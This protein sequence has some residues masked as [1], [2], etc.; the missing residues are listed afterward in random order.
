V[1]DAER[2][3]FGGSPAPNRSL[4]IRRGFPRRGRHRNK[5]AP[6]C[7]TGPEASAAARA[8]H[9]PRPVGRTQCIRFETAPAL[10]CL[11][12]RRRAMSPT[13]GIRPAHTL[14]RASCVPPISE[15]HPMCGPAIGRN[16]FSAIC[17]LCSVASLYPASV[18]GVVLGAILDAGARS[19]YRTRLERAILR[20]K[21]RRR[22]E[23]RSSISFPPHA[24]AGNGRCRRSLLIRAVPLF[25]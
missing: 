17:R 2:L 6:A 14:S 7:A 19:R 21:F 11:Q 23:D 16:R 3:R 9:L 8:P 22:R 5:P 1:K 24:A 20:H 4:V 10:T 13:F 18:G 15:F 12:A 25:V